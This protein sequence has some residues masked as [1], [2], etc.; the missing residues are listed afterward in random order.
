MFDPTYP[1][2]PIFAFVGFFLVLIPLPWHLQAWN[3]GTCYFMMWASLACLNQFVN[4]IVWADNA[5]NV[6]PIWCEISIRIMMGASVGLPASSLCINRRLYYISSAQAVMITH[7][8]KLR[9]ILVDTLICVVFPVVFIALQYIVQGHRFDI[10]ENIGCYPALFNTPLTYFLSI[11]WPIVIGLISAVFCVLSLRSFARRRVEFGQFLSSNTSLTISRY[12]RLMA[13]AMSDIVFTT[14]PAI[15]MLWLNLSA[16]TVSP[17]V[18]W[19]DTHFDYSRVVQYPA[20]LW[21]SDR[22]TLIAVE[23]TRWVT[24]LCALI[25][26]AFFGFADEAK[27]NYRR[28]FWFLAKPFGFRPA[29]PRAAKPINQYK[30]PSIPLKCAESSLPPYSPPSS[31]STFPSRDFKS[32]DSSKSFTISLDDTFT[33]LSEPSDSHS[34]Y[35]NE[36]PPSTTHRTTDPRLAGSI[37]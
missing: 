37:V 9:N 31:A 29:T 24:P 21:R 35:S 33:I 18:S 11:M 8:D 7:A 36:L 32:P 19:E 14:P 17:W 12:F 4:S 5:L 25:F 26:F 13:L 6:A 23:F 27:R 34:I 1:L 16:T 28:A 22:L 10:F 15:F 3:S 2:F 20:I 30:P